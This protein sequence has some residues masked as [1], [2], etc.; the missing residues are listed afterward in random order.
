MAA[1]GDGRLTA[2]AIGKLTGRDD[3]SLP[4]RVLESTLACALMLID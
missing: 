2:A 4:W 3:V 1:A